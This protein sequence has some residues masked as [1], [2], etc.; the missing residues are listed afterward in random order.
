MQHLEANLLGGDRVRAVYHPSTSRANS[1]SKRLASVQLWSVPWEASLFQQALQQGK[2]PDSEQIR[3]AMLEQ[4]MFQ[5]LHPLVKAG[6]GNWRG[7]ME[8]KSLDG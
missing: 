4:S 2:G 3:Q 8:G 5:T 7:M 1:S 6:I